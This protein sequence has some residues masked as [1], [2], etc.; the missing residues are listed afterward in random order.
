VTTKILQGVM[1]L[2]PEERTRRS[3]EGRRAKNPLWLIGGGPWLVLDYCP[4]TQHNTLKA[5]RGTRVENRTRCVCPHACA[6]LAAFSKTQ[7]AQKRAARQAE[8]LAQLEAKSAAPPPVPK[9]KPKPALLPG[10]SVSRYLRNVSG[11][12]GP[13]SLPG[14][15]CASVPQLFDAALDG[16][17]TGE[18]RAV[19]MS[20]PVRELC[21]A[22]VLEDEKPA[23]DWGGVYGGLSVAD[24]RRY[25]EAQTKSVIAPNPPAVDHG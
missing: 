16:R 23:G 22:W 13:P 2:P 11:T 5:A 19:C 18:A 24:R 4:A 10:S 14:R 1:L 17:R 6:L 12:S 8:M 21:A 15:R 9:P 7:A 20:C 25:A 3:M